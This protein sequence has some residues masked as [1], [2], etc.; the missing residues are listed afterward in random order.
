MQPIRHGGALESTSNASSYTDVAGAYMDLDA[1][2]TYAQIGAKGPGSIG[3]KLRT[4]L[5]GVVLTAATIAANA[6]VTFAESVTMTAGK[7]LA[8]QAV[9][10]TTIQ[11]TGLITANAGV[12]VASGQTLTLTGATIAGTPTWSSSQ[13]I[14]LSTAAQP[15]VTSLGTLTSLT[16][17]GAIS[18]NF[19]GTGSNFNVIANVNGFAAGAKVGVRIQGSGGSTVTEYGWD[20]NNSAFYHSTAVNVAGILSVTVLS[21][22]NL[23]VSKSTGASIVYDQSGTTRALIEGFNGSGGLRFYAG[24]TG[25]WKYDSTG[26]L[27]DLD[28]T[29]DLGALGA[30]RFRDL[31]LARKFVVGAGGSTMTSASA[32][33]VL[34]LTSGDVGSRPLLATTPNSSTSYGSYF[35]AGGS[36]WTNPSNEGLV[37]V[38]LNGSAADLAMMLMNSKSVTL[39]LSG[40][41]GSGFGP[42]MRFMTAF[43]PKGYLGL[44][45][46]VIGG[47]SE[48]LTLYASSGLSI[49]FYADA[50][51]SPQLLISSQY[52]TAATGITF[53]GRSDDTISVLQNIFSDNATRARGFSS[54]ATRT[55]ASTHINFVNPNGG[56]GS[57]TTSG[58]ATAFNTSS[59]RRL[60]IDRGRAR[61]ISVLSALVIHEYEWIS[62]DGISWGVFAQEAHEIAPWAVT[63]G[64]NERDR[65]GNLISPWSVDY[66]RFIPDLIVGWQN[67]E[68]RLFNVEQRLAKLEA[69]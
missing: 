33:N 11:A 47:T 1:G 15:N 48:N 21:G 17:S 68:A 69:A 6:Q 41:S 10:A 4:I 54:E 56:V 64:S 28:N 40:G 58:S 67:H 22:S 60:K 16:T 3:L 39:N 8:A 36:S 26:V 2:G 49:E 5:A 53:N 7:T 44:H 66:S 59:D 32:A 25:I 65:R 24:V 23:S 57:V 12:T 20:F 43:T 50:A 30:N 46:G 27:A 34:S 19:T 13:A 61:D 14:T 35:V 37:N 52:I 29:Y 18:T 62:G 42:F 45:R 51:A 63:V 31:H 9:T 55:S 38:D